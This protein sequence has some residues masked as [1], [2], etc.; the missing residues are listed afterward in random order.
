MKRYAALYLGKASLFGKGTELMSAFESKVVLKEQGRS[1]D[2]LRRSLQR[3]ANV[4]YQHNY[5][6]SL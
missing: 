4:E 5:I 3:P 6:V 2:F 1:V